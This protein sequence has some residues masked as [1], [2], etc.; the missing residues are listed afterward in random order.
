MT[1][2][3]SL[4]DAAVAAQRRGNYVEAEQRLRELIDACP[5][6]AEARNDLGRIVLADGRI[7]E[8]IGYF[9]KAIEIKPDLGQAHFNLAVVYRG[10]GSLEPAARHYLRAAELL[11]NMATTHYHLALVL[12]DLGQV[13]N[14]VRAMHR[15][16]E[17]SPESLETHTR[18]AEM[19]TEVGRFD[20]A[21]D[22]YD[23]VIAIEPNHLPAWL[24]K[25]CIHE[26]QDQAEEAVLCL[27]KVLALDPEQHDVRLKLGKLLFK[28]GRTDNAIQVFNEAVRVRPDWPEARYHLSLALLSKGRLSDAWPE[29]EARKQCQMGSWLTHSLPEWDGRLGERKRILTYGEQGIGHELMLASC[30]PELISEVRHCVIE[31]D[32]RLTNIFM[33]SFP[34]ATVI[35]SS[36]SAVD[37]NS[38]LGRAVD[39]QIAMGSLPGRYRTKYRE[40]PERADYLRPD[41]EKTQN[42]R[43]KLEQL[44]DGL[45]V[46]LVRHG[47]EFEPSG[48][49]SE[50]TTPWSPLLT[51]RD[52]H[53]IELVDPSSPLPS[54]GGVTV[55]DWSDLGA[56]KDVDQLAALAA[57]LDVV[58]TTDHFAAHLAAAVGTQTWVVLDEEADWRWMLDSRRSPWHPTMRLFQKARGET[59]DAVFTRV[60]CE[61]V[62]HLV[63]RGMDRPQV[64]FRKEAA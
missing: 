10:K 55:H 61:L 57:E 53:W 31:C 38:A 52:C 34:Y 42:W 5:D 43:R 24:T 44:G 4:I 2:A 60:R 54:P 13:A 39:A 64:R 26:V 18:L 19:L 23:A 35:A 41:F 28:T 59:W 48:A 46:G 47:L 11:P 17:L 58:I 49:K 51:A 40:F 30:L 62:D 63:R 36:T 16:V 33:R 1:L 9:E 22:A 14:A 7:D 20:E 50:R 27:R 32:P 37:A 12:R 3:T 6:H 56:E 45:K 25:G 8:A 29:F 21:I 15:A